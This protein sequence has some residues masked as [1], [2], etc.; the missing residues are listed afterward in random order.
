MG[1]VTAKQGFFCFFQVLPVF[2][3][4]SNFRFAVFGNW[5]VGAYITLD[6]AV[7]IAYP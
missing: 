2:F 1:R 6:N 4:I 3:S 5:K 7:S